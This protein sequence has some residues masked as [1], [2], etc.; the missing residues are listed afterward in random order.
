MKN[1]SLLIFV[2]FAGL[3]GG[4]SA[5]DS[6]EL[7][8]A[9]EAFKRANT[10]HAAKVAPAQ[11]RMATQALA[12]AEQSFQD[13]P[14]SN[15]TLDLAIIARRRSEMVEATASRAI[16]R[17]RH[18]QVGKFFGATRGEIVAKT[19]QDLRQ[20]R[21]ALEESKRGDKKIGKRIFA[22]YEAETA[23]R[24]READ[25]LAALTK[26]AAVKEGPRGTVITLSGNMLFA[27]N[28]AIF[29][30]DAR[31]RLNQIAGVLLTT[32]ER[33]L[34]IK[35]YTDSEGSESHNANLSQRRADAFR[36]YL[37]RRGYQADQIQAYGLGA[38]NPVA[39]NTST[40]GRSNNRRVEIIIERE[41]RRPKQQ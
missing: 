30:P 22:K 28:R 3:L 10:E 11:L 27:S 19:N 38:R 29:S 36:A 4:C 9:R 23:T 39:D 26:L 2:T 33:N 34:I 15:Q 13:N 17:S 8:D 1:H 37:V 32:S 31:V 24:K 21:K 16:A 25:A 7:L 14:D 41:M 35:G 5:T 12:R 20:R 6:K 18:T 40:E